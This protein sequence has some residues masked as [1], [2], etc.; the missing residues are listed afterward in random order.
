MRKE[1]FKW[2]A[3]APVV[4]IFGEDVPREAEPGK[5]SVAPKPLTKTAARPRTPVLPELPKAVQAPGSATTTAATPK[6]LP[7]TVTHE[8]KP[9][10]KTPR[11]IQKSEPVWEK[12]V[13]KHDGKT[14]IAPTPL[15]LF[16]VPGEVKP[17]VKIMPLKT[18]PQRS[19]EA[20]QAPGSAATAAAA[21][22]PAASTA[23]ANKPVTKPQV[24]TKAILAPELGGA[25]P[26]RTGTKPVTQPKLTLKDQPKAIL[27]PELKG[28]QSTKTPAS[29][30]TKPLSRGIVKPI[31]APE[32][33]AE[34]P[35]VTEE[36]AG[37]F[38]VDQMN[39]FLKNASAYMD[40]YNARFG[41]RKGGLAG[42]YVGDSQEFLDAAY[43][44][45]QSLITTADAIRAVLHQYGST[46]D[47]EGVEAVTKTLDEIMA[48]VRQMY[49]GAQQDNAYW[50]S[51]GSA[52]TEES[53][54]DVYQKAQ[55]EQMF[56]EK[57]AGKSGTEL[58]NLIN[59][60]EDEDEKA[61][62]TGEALRTMSFDEASEDLADA[63][64]ALAELEPLGRLINSA[65]SGLV[66]DEKQVAAAYQRRKEI[67]EKYGVKSYDELRDM[68]T[69]NQQ[70][71]AES[72]K[73]Q[74]YI[75]LSSVQ[76]NKDFDKYAKEGEAEAKEYAQKN[77]KTEHMTDQEIQ[78]LAYY[79]AKDKE[80]GTNLADEYKA[81]I[82]HYL[83]HRRAQEIAASINGIDIPVIEGLTRI[84]YSLGS[85]VVDW[86]LD[87]AQNFTNQKIDPTVMQMA[88]G[89]IGSDPSLNG[90]DRIAHQAAGAVGYMAPS[91][92]LSKGVSGLTGMASLGSAVG[93]TTMFLGSAGNAYGDALEKGYN[94]P[95]ARAYSALVGLSEVTLQN[96]LGGISEFGGLP[97]KLDGKISAI[98]NA[99][100]KGAAKYGIS[101]GSEILEEELQNFLEPAFRSII[102]GEKYDMP[103]VQEIIDTALVTALSTSTIE[104]PGITSETIKEYGYNNALP[105][106]EIES[107]TKTAKP[108]EVTQSL[109]KV[110]FT[111]AEIQSVQ[112]IGRKSVN[113]FN[114][115][116][117]AATEKLAQRHW[118]ELG[119]KSPFYRA[120]N[121][122]WRETDQTT[123]QIAT[124]PDATRGVQQ[125]ADTGWDIQVSGKVFAESQHLAK[126]NSTAIQYLPYI[127]DIVKNAVLLDSY[128][129]DSGKAKSQNSLLMHSMYAVADIGKGPEVLKLYVEEM[130]DPNKT[131]TVKRAYQLQNIE[132]ASAVNGGVQGVTSSPLANTANAVHTVA[133]LFAAVKAKDAAF[134]LKPAPKTTNGKVGWDGRVAVTEAKGKNITIDGKTYAL[135]G[136]DANGT[137]VYQDVEVLKEQSEQAEFKQPDDGKKVEVKGERKTIE[138]PKKSGKM[139]ID[140]GGR[141]N[142]TALNE[143]QFAKA[144]EAAMAQGY[145]GE[146]FYRDN[147]STSFHAFQNVGDE[148]AF[149]YLVIG[150]DAYPKPN[151]NGEAVERISLNGC[152]AHEV[153]GHYEAWK[154]GNTQSSVPLEEAQASIRAAK[155]GV[156]LT[157]EERAV[158]FEDGMD[159]LR[160][161][162]IAYEDVK[163]ILDIWER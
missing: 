69:R 9:A 91:I 155:F 163:K 54:E 35:E 74:E 55:Q 124:K 122:D 138:N 115:Q 145:D 40:E 94:Q 5:K 25:Q 3:D 97:A 7:E 95:A 112:S 14:A 58:V 39:S 83:K 132:K 130:N 62:V 118:E 10:L 37:K 119:E 150:T 106:T 107:D 110:K 111:D 82:K 137:P 19:A 70:L 131:T 109:A 13:L 34:Q 147:S 65:E 66:V 29:H 76:E 87:L 53:A 6:R 80:N 146:I 101:L 134:Q 100:L 123:V 93:S 16:T 38:V 42:A 162:G 67:Y 133:D 92:L 160:A 63:K 161:A 153:V 64:Y 61:W 48:Q 71:I 72:Q 8:E 142:E 99:L 105:Q 102:F 96:I 158:L 90:F 22:N 103:T 129:M 144:K 15:P 89:Y 27:A 79:I 51:W 139:K 30:A 113:S 18:Q 78:I 154:R 77:N 47:P 46:M 141:R 156:G 128:A 152:M 68:I 140:T 125:N 33:A 1:Q 31:L 59:F 114:A 159:R 117:I 85:G 36:T 157:E 81:A 86:S 88:N 104:G 11:V 45:T 24:M 23:A 12:P 21:Y 41:S 20:V 43:Q 32:L 149:Y 148:G 17:A 73:V 120:E 28:E 49:Q 108:E 116:D 4:H 121:G 98:K 143:K 50:N 126:K 135:L 127:N 2:A 60:I 44:K 56:A 84:G 52:G 26:V 57:Y 136:K 75:R 151:A